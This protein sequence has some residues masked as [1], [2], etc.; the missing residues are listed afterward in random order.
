M[1]HLLSCTCVNGFVTTTV[2]ANVC[3]CVLGMYTCMYVQCKVTCV[4]VTLYISRDS[5]MSHS[6]HDCTYNCLYLSHPFIPQASVHPGTWYTSVPVLESPTHHFLG[7]SYW[8]LCLSLA[9]IVSIELLV[10]YGG[11]S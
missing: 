4:S 11:V 3:L 5:R 8:E 2:H 9:I 10:L 7:F 6:L 1:H